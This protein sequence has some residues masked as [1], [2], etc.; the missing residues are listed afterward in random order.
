MSTS[1]FY[2][3]K[4]TTTLWWKFFPMHIYIQTYAQK[5]DLRC[6]DEIESLQQVAYSNNYVFCFAYR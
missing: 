4:I 2:L 6:C 1:Q 3:P 5:W